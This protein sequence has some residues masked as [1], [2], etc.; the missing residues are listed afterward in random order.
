ML[1]FVNESDHRLIKSHFIKHTHH[2]ELKKIY[3][4]KLPN[5]YRPVPH[6]YFIFLL[7]INNI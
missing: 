1:D 7:N 3:R 2:V 6:Q 5:T 4:E